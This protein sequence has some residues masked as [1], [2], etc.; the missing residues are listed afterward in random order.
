MFKGKYIDTYLVCKKE[1]I[2]AVHIIFNII[3]AAFDGAKFATWVRDIGLEKKHY[4]EERMEGN[5]FKIE[6]IAFLDAKNET[7]IDKGIK[8]FLVNELKLSS[9]DFYVSDISSK[10]IIDSSPY[11]MT[12]SKTK[13]KDLL[14]PIYS[15]KHFIRSLNDLILDFGF[16][17]VG[18]YSRYYYHNGYAYMGDQYLDKCNE[19][20]L[21]SKAV[22]EP[23]NKHI[24]QALFHSCYSAEIIEIDRREVEGKSLLKLNV[25]DNFFLYH[26]TCESRLDVHNQLLSPVINMK[27]RN[28]A[29]LRDIFTGFF[30]KVYYGDIHA[31]SDAVDINIK[32][33]YGFEYDY[34][35]DGNCLMDFKN[36]K[37]RPVSS[38]EK[39]DFFEFRN[40]VKDD[41]T[42]RIEYC[43]AVNLMSRYKV[44]IEKD[45]RKLISWNDFDQ[46]N[47]NILT[48]DYLSFTQNRVGKQSLKEALAF[49]KRV[50]QD[51]YN[52][53]SEVNKIFYD[54]FFSEHTENPTNYHLVK[55]EAPSANDFCTFF[56][57]DKDFFI[58]N[59]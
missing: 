51:F 55:Q 20:G 46:K 16:D 18:K 23:K 59:D 47:S 57:Y 12:S 30:E 21:D 39:I 38:N 36:P 8:L 22:E 49:T 34:L 27:V 37:W 28:C 3:E 10:L 41:P 19:L 56:I 35:D 7:E 58:I 53:K 4:E 43:K 42:I 50:D 9:T 52:F 17:M 1:G 45:S 32:R 6:L 44:F 25:G 31:D 48:V 33:L 24:I 15:K 54:Y 5:L 13:F 26:P 29:L 2:K 40:K 11:L 14:L